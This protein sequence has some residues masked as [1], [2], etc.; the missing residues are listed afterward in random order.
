MEWIKDRKELS[1][2]ARV[3]VKSWCAEPEPE[4]LKQAA[5]LAAHPVVEHHVA[6]MPDCHVGYGMPIGGVIGCR[7]AVIPNAVGVD[8]G[9]GMCAVKTSA[10][11]EQMRDLA[12]IRAILED[13][14]KLV[15]VGEG[16][17]HKRQQEWDGFA[18]FESSIE[19]DVPAW[20]NQD[21]LNHDRKNL[22]T[23]GGGNHF[24]EVQASEDGTVWLMLHS[25]SRN[26]GH[27]IAS[28]Y[29]RLAQ[30]LNQRWHADLPS[31]DLAFL[32][33]ETGEGQG[34]VRDMTFALAYALENRRR[35]MAAAKSVMAEHLPGIGFVEEINIHHNYA[36]L[37][38]HFGRNLW[39]HRKGAT[40]AREGELGII[41]GSM[42]TP[43]Y[44]VRGRGNPESFMSCSHGAGRSMGRTEASRRLTLEEC[45]RAMQGVVYDRWHKAGG[46]SKKR[47][48]KGI[49]Y[50]F[51][52]APQAYKDIDQVIAAELDLIEPLVKLRPLGVIKG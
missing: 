21:G 20:F 22:G 11:V 37:E 15:P 40:S 7:E 41:P 6:L 12:F 19:R 50:D 24:I 47:R 39:V 33:L 49:D 28:F 35:M 13:V 10:T 2:S 25:G 1:E 16:N 8:I 27:R 3:P 31:P 4:A 17:S 43:S 51:G 23:L 5:N 9:C 18:S 26:L 52:E 36:K 34:Y 45:D 30:Q 48:E 42:G 38:H 29:H 32:P 44:I 46:G 14:K